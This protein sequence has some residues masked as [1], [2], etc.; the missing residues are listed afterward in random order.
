MRFTRHLALMQNRGGLSMCFILPNAVFKA[1]DLISEHGFEVFCVGGCV[2]DMIRNKTPKDYDLATNA[3]P[4]ELINIFSS[5]HCILTGIQHGTIQV[6]IDDLFIEMSTY[7]REGDRRVLDKSKQDSDSTLIEDLSCRDL[8]INAMAYHPTIGLIDPFQGQL[9]LE[10]KLI[11]CVKEPKLRFQEDPLRM[12]RVIRFSTDLGF[13]VESKTKETLINDAELLE[14]VSKERIQ[15]ELTKILM[16]SSAP[17]GIHMLYQT[18]LLKQIFAP[19]SD[20]FSCTQS[21]PHHYTDVG[22]HTLDALRYFYVENLFADLSIQEQK[23]VLYAILLHDAGKV[24]TKT[25]DEK[26][27]DHFYGH[28]EIS[29]KIAEDFLRLF[30]FSNYEKKVI[31]KIIGLHD[32]QFTFKKRCVKKLLFQHE[33]F[34]DSM[35]LLINLKICDSLAHINGEKKMLENKSFYEY[36]LK[37][38]NTHPYQISHLAINGND[39]LEIIPEIKGKMIKHVLQECLNL[40]FDNPERNTKEYLRNFIQRGKR[41]F[42]KLRNE[43][44]NG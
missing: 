44:E 34:P 35:K 18:G 21:N 25:T 23:I 9:D 12:M 16:C 4:E 19:L 33:I 27:L 10:A 6:H 24:P 30:R 43:V 14:N 28:P 29:K 39:V 2:R 40:V 38:V 15:D 8:T 11:R 42:L 31:V 7:R 32:Y 37:I 3:T 22:S 1:M 5:Y 36:Y 20:M 13:I 41:R 26:G 17:R